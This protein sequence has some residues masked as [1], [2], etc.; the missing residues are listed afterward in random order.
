MKSPAIRNNWWETMGCG[1]FPFSSQANSSFFGFS[2]G[3]FQMV[4]WQMFGVFRQKDTWSETLK[5]NWVNSDCLFQG[6]N[7]NNT[8]TGYPFPQALGMAWVVSLC[9]PRDVR[10]RG[11]AI[12]VENQSLLDFFRSM[13]MGEW[14][15]TNSIHPSFDH[16]TYRF[17]WAGYLFPYTKKLA[18]LSPDLQVYI[19]KRRK[20]HLIEASKP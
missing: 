3:W 12:A 10:L 18:A 6:R 9:Y 8:T 16:G 13:V 7:I 20:H 4:S 5:V 17:F 19:L 14:P 1:V 2:G 15:A 11:A